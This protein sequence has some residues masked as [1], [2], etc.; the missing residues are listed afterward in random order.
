MLRQL[1][2]VSRAKSLAK[3]STRSNGLER[4][5]SLNGTSSGDSAALAFPSCASF[6]SSSALEQSARPR[7]TSSYQSDH[8]DDYDNRSRPSRRRW[9]DRDGSE[10]DFD[11]RRSDNGAANRYWQS[12]RGLQNGSSRPAMNVRDTDFGGTALP[13]GDPVF[14]SRSQARRQTLEALESSGSGLARRPSLPQ[15]TKDSDPVGWLNQKLTSFGRFEERQPS[16]SEVEDIWETYS[17]IRTSPARLASVSAYTFRNLSEAIRVA[18]EFNK[19]AFVETG[20]R[21]LETDVA[22]KARITKGLERLKT[23]V[24]DMVSLGLKPDN[25]ISWNMSQTARLYFTWVG[26]SSEEWSRQ[27]S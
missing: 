20:R 1:S 16:A 27:A 11:R 6:H 10:T 25:R 15:I 14:P 8:N 22:T 9:V 26:S 23:L 4:T 12:D 21:E 19:G 18:S 17:K 5:T 3:S 24:L 7:R 2:R 13:R